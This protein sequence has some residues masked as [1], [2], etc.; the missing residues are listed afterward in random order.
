MLQLFLSC[1]ILEAKW[2]SGK[3][4]REVQDKMQHDAEM[5][6]KDTVLFFNRSH[7]SGP[8]QM[9][10]GILSE[11]SVLCIAQPLLQQSF[12]PPTPASHNS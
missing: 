10:I 9:G 8:G 5:W 7:Q 6:V 4:G 12:L 2:M 11:M 3:W 1:S